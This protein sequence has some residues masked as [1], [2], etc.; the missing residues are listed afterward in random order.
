LFLVTSACGAL[1]M[2]VA[3]DASS[4]KDASPTCAAETDAAFCA[5]LGATCEDE[6]AADNCGT[7]RTA[8]CGTCGGTDACVAN[9]CKAPVC[10]SFAFPNQ[11][12]ATALNDTGKQDAVTGVTPDGKT[13]LSQR[14]QSCGNFRLILSDTSGLVTTNHDLTGNAELSAMQIA[15]E[16]TLALT[17]DG[18]TIIG[19]SADGTALLASHRAA[20][21]SATFSAATGTDFTNLAVVAPRRIDFPVISSDDLALYYRITGDADPSVDGLYESVRTSTSVP[22]PAG[23][24]MSNLVSSFGAVTGISTD[25]MTLFLQ[26][27]SFSTVALTR[28]SLVQPFTNPNMPAPPPVVPGF[29]TRPLGDCNSLV[30]TCTP[31]G[32][33]GEEVCVF[34]K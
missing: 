28:R 33:A 16:G 14:G 21:G 27:N 8:S 30:A 12:L 6:T 9:V 5:R 25:R 4:S 29:R 34:T 15:S 7:M 10:S 32:C 22:F 3:P 13:I 17:A 24:R 2:P 11:T 1:E 26:T 31:G 20:L 19:T 23:T 18:L